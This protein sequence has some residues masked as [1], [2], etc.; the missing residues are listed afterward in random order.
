MPANEA[1]GGDLTEPA[2]AWPTC[3]GRRLAGRRTGREAGHYSCE[4][5]QVYWLHLQV[6]TYKS[7][8]RGGGSRGCG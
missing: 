1:G 2:P 5:P 8:H 7:V 4:S 3:T 6:N